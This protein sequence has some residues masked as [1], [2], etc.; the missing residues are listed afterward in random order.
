MFTGI[1]KSTLKRL[2]SN[3]NKDLVKMLSLTSA[4]LLC[5]MLY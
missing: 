4:I 2:K 3:L 5:R 1:L